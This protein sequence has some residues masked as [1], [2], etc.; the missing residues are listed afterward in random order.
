LFIAA[1]PLPTA[2]VTTQRVTN[3]AIF[4]AASQCD[5]PSPVLPNFEI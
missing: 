3:T 4:I 1:S 2:T 5:R